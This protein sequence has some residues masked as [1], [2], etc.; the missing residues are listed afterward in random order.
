VAATHRRGPSGSTEAIKSRA[1][2]YTRCTGYGPDR[3]LEL[4]AAKDSGFTANTFI[5]ALRA[6]HRLGPADWTED[7]ITGEAPRPPTRAVR[8]LARPPD[9]FREAVTDTG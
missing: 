5:D 9:P 3:L 8:Q 1:R 6:I 2:S 4:A 7:G